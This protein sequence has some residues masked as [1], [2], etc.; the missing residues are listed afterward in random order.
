MAEPKIFFVHLRRPR[1]NDQRSDPFYEFGSFGCTGC[2]SSNLLHKN[3]AAKLKG[4][5]L[6][7]VQGGKLGSRLVLLTPPIAVVKKWKEHCE[8]KRKWISIREVRWKPMDMPFTYTEA[9]VLVSNDGYS[10]FPSVKEFARG[11]HCPTLVSGLASLIRSRAC[12]LDEQM[13]KE[14]VAVYKRWRRKA[15]ATHSGI[16]STYDETMLP[17]PRVLD[18]NRKA[19]YRSEI[20]KLVSDNIGADRP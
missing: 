19:T 8:K 6:A 13:A 10:H 18:P 15:T 4:A 14:V 20:K 2:H 7:F 5:R 12:A 3:R 16:A 17:A 1:R 9:P 11:T